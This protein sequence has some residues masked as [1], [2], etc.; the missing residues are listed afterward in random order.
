M[1]GIFP[2]ILKTLKLL[3]TNEHVSDKDRKTKMYCAMAFQK[4]LPSD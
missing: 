3:L 1:F 4:Y 2:F